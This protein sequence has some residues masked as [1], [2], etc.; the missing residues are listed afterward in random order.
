[1]QQQTDKKVAVVM[2]QET[3]DRYENLLGC[4]F[5]KGFIAL[6]TKSSKPKY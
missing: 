6:K 5:D 3:K 1:M 4:C 2:V